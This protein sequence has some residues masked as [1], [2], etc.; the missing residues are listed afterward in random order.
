MSEQGFDADHPNID[1]LRLRN[2]TMG[3]KLDDSEIL[4]PNGLEKVISIMKCLKPLVS[5]LSSVR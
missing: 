1:L 5:V 4:G 3:R 2:F